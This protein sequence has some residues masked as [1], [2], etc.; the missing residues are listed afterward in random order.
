MVGALE[1]ATEVMVEVELGHL[2]VVGHTG[3]EDMGVAVEKA[4]KVVEVDT[5]EEAVPLSLRLKNVDKIYD[6]DARKIS[7]LSRGIY[8]FIRG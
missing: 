5:E 3:E 4:M 2:E 8:F 1:K 6:V 7:I